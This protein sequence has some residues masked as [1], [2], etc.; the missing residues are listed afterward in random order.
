[1]VCFLRG[2]CMASHNGSFNFKASVTFSITKQLRKESHE[3]KLQQ[4]LCCLWM[5]LNEQ[6]TQMAQFSLLTGTTVVQAT[7]LQLQLFTLG[8]LYAHEIHD[9]VLQS[10][11]SIGIVTAYVGKVLWESGESSNSLFSYSRRAQSCDR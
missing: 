3:E 10:V 4:K 11:P 7:A 5:T 1:M 6:N 2:S 8:T 9:S